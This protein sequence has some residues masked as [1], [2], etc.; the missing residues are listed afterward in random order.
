MPVDNRQK[1]H[2]FVLEYLSAAGV[3]LKKSEEE[4]LPVEQV[5]AASSTEL[6][7][8]PYIKLWVHS[9]WEMKSQK[10]LEDSGKWLANKTTRVSGGEMLLTSVNPSIRQPAYSDTAGSTPV[11]WYIVRSIAEQHG[12]LMENMFLHFSVDTTPAVASCGPAWTNST[13]RNPLQQDTRTVFCW[14]A[15]I[16]SLPT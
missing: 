4:V 12:Y 1:D 16:Q 14:S 6:W 7:I 2:T 5:A 13:W 9:L 15:E 10:R 11:G 3:V 8:K